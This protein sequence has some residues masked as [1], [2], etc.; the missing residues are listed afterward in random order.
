MPMAFNPLQ[1]L[2]FALIELDIFNSN[3]RRFES[4]LGG[5]LPVSGDMQRTKDWL[6]TVRRQGENYVLSNCDSEI[7]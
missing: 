2:L 3:G 1:P 5:C 4:R 7:C 6:T